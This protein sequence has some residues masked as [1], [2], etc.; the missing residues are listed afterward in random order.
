MAKV[1]NEEEITREIYVFPER[2][3]IINDLGL[4]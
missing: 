4:T 1:S 3:Q 2:Q